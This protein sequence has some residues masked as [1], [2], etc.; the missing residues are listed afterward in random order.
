ME[1]YNQRSSVLRMEQKMYIMEGLQMRHLMNK[2][3]AVMAVLGGMMLAV[4]GCGHEHS[5]TEATCTAPKTC[6]SCGETEGD[7]LE[8]S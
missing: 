6:D 5:W 2:R 8:H 4:T 7:V 1:A 3:L